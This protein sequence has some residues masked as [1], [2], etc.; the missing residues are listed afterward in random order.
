MSNKLIAFALIFIIGFS[1]VAEGQ[2]PSG[3]GQRGSGNRQFQGGTINGQIID[4]YHKKPIEYATISLFK[5]LDSTLVNGTVS[6]VEGNF[7]ISKIRPGAYYITV[8][9]MG[10]EVYKSDKI[11]IKRE[12]L[13]F[14]TGPI[15]LIQSSVTV[16]GIKVSEEK[17]EIEYKIDK[18]VINV[19]RQ[20]TST[21]GTAI[22]VLENVPSVS[23]DIDGN[24]SLRGSSNFTVLIDGRPSILDANDALEQIPAS[25][26]ENIELITNPS[27][28]FDPDGTAGIINIILK[29]NKIGGLSGIIKSNAGFDEN[30][31]GD[32]LLNYRNGFYNAFV[33][34]NYRNGSRPGSSVENR[35]T[36]Y[37][38]TYSYLNSQG[39]QG[40]GHDGS[41]IRGGVDWT[42][43]EKD[44][45]T[46]GF[47]YG[48][49]NGGHNSFLYYDSWTS[50]DPTHD[51]F[52]SNSNSDRSGNFYAIYMDYQHKFNTK[53]H[54]LLASAHLSRRDME[55]L[56]TDELLDINGDITSGNKL[57]EFGPGDQI[58]LKADY[59]YPI[60]E[61]DKFEAGYQ[62][63]L[64]DSDDKNQTFEYD[65]LTGEFIDLPE[66]KNGTTYKRDIHSIYTL[67]ASELSR[68]GFQ[69]GLRAEYTNREII[70]IDSSY[71]FS[72][73]R[74]DWYPTIH[75]SFDLSDSQQLMG[76][77]ARRVDH[78]RGWF[79]EPFITR[80]DAYNVR[81]GNPGLEPEFI[82]SYELSYMKSVGRAVFSVESYYRI[83]HNKVEFVQSVYDENITL[84]SVENVGTDY[85]FGM[86]FM[87]NRPMTAF[88]NINAMADFYNY[89]V[90]G[91]LLGKSYSNES[92]SWSARLNNMFTINDKTSLQL[93]GNYQSNRS[94]SQGE[95]N[96]FFMSSMA[97]KYEFI[98]RTLTATLQVR[99][100]FQSSDRERTLEAEDFY[101]YSS[102][103]RKAPSVMLNL[104]YL[105][106]NFKENKKQNQAGE[107]LSEDDF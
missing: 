28:K 91:E 53:G 82:D 30:Y 19:E 12:Q 104:T 2:M 60:N 22:D 106:N 49:R 41:G 44:L 16:E 11:E 34:V 77:Y 1:A 58:R 107:D 56:S 20:L 100:L 29:K 101:S 97:L 89:K 42:L 50:A 87:V 94:N 3:A 63:R 55:D 54:Q 64:G 103:D 73:D 76:S 88:W 17:P 99:D 9:F 85:S 69:G 65:P 59:T 32:I 27:A 67:Y 15:P 14:E 57:I 5:L 70:I 78:P 51:Y 35:W 31:G 47:S 61:T 21:S 98:K 26:I 52:T 86:E 37:N 90:E 36:L 18:K 92:F 71:Q 96:G 72:I 43:G 6:D 74:W 45:L 105:F 102:F 10:F 66:Y 13:E 80:V 4:S 8:T 79:L 68:I 84:N 38:G 81:S 39:S 25:S 75:L 7:K 83:T 24:V 33:N 48:E 62:S 93:M 95:S 23:V 46:T 40:G